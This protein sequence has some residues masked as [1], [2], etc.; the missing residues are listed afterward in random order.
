MQQID[1]LLKD[2]PLG[3]KILYILSF[4]VFVIGL[5]ITNFTLLLANVSY[6]T[7]ANN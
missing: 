1:T 3:C 2:I 6:F 4:V 5:F 7:Y